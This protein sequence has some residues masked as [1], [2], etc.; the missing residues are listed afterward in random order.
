MNK[1]I[2]VALATVVG[3]A[4]VASATIT[5]TPLGTGAPPA[6]LGGKA[7]TYND[8]TVGSDPRGDGAVVSDF[9]YGGVPLVKSSVPLSVRTLG[10]SWATWSHGFGGNVYW[11]QGATDMTFTFNKDVSAF[12]FYAEPNPFDTFD[13]TATGSDPGD[14]VSLTQAVTGDSGA[15]GWGFT[16]TSGSGITSVRV[17]SSVDYAV[18]EIGI[19]NV[20]APG[21]AALG[22]IGLGL[23]AR[24]RR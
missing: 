11:T 7:L 21:S 1:M 4:T 22:L 17:S 13:I 24:R 12:V 23:I 3:T 10:L 19:G 5:A 16:S 20:P 6:S 9:L 18:G 8:G 2:G 14:T 15:T